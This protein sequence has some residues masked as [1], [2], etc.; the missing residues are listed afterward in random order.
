M[1]G[2]GQI[3]GGIRRLRR[4]LVI[5]HHHKP[6]HDQPAKGAAPKDGPAKIQPPKPAAAM[7]PKATDA[8]PSAPAQASP[9]P[10]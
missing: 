8:P 7:A 9:P 4:A 10:Q 3:R 5:L 1:C 6:T 2:R